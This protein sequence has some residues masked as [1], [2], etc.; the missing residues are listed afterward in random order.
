MFGL[1]VSG[2]WVRDVCRKYVQDT[3][4]LEISP[5]PHMNPNRAGLR[6]SRLCVV[7]KAKQPVK[8]ENKPIL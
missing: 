5:D 4:E 1:I 8:T 2:H 6:I 7:R 3:K